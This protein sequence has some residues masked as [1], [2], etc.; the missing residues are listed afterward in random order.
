MGITRRGKRLKIH[1]VLSLNISCLSINST[2]QDLA[3]TESDSKNQLGT[4]P[5]MPTEY[6]VI[7]GNFD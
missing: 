6:L 1:S 5:D 4:E 3:K 2:Q 7:S